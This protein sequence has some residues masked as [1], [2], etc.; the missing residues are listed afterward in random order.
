MSLLEIKKRIAQSVKDARKEHRATQKELAALLGITQA[1]YSQIE[2]G[3]G[4]FSAEQLIILIQRFNLSISRFV[5]Q[6][7]EDDSSLKLQKAL[8]RFGANQLYEDPDILPSQ[9]LENVA[10]VIIETI[11]SA[12]SS[13]QIVALAPVIVKNR[14]QI[15][16][17][18]IKNELQVL[19]YLGRLGWVLES[20]ATAIDSEL[21]H[22]TPRRRELLYKRTFA[23]IKIFIDN[24][25]IWETLILEDILD[26][27]IYSAKTLNEVKEARDPLAKK[28]R[29][30]TRITTNDFINALR[31]AQID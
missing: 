10:Q 14:A 22:V 9:K 29:I 7:S 17:T 31:E 4:S 12:G 20:V 5:S 1:R 27:N 2:S 13:R 28:W 3:K 30:I 25:R 19:G 23:N 15:N 8:Y 16:F 6:K 24:S 11:L 21:F 18:K 26:K